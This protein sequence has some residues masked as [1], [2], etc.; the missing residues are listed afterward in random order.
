MRNRYGR[1]NH[2]TDNERQH[3]LN[4]HEDDLHPEKPPEGSTNRAIEKI[5]LVSKRFG[6]TLRHFSLQAGSIRDYEDRQHQDD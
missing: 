5:E 1:P 4:D 6:I 3:D 2:Q